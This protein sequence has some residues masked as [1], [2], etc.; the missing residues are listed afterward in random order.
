MDSMSFQFNWEEY[1]ETYTQQVKELIEKKALGELYRNSQF[2][3]PEVKPWKS[4]LEKM[5]AT[6][7]E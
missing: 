7:E 1:T 6:L 4:E 3:P 5:L 2:K